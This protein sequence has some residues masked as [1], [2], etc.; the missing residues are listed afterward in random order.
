VDGFCGA[1]SLA[2]T[3][4][5]FL[6]QSTFVAD[7]VN[8][9]ISR[10]MAHQEAQQYAV[11][12]DYSH[13]LIS[14]CQRFLA[15]VLELEPDKFVAGVNTLIAEAPQPE[16]PAEAVMAWFVLK[17][18]VL[19]GAEDHHVWFHQRV[20]K[21]TCAFRSRPPAAPATFA[22]AH[23]AA[24]LGG[25]A[26]DYGRTF[27]AAHRW[28]AAIKAAGLLRA[29]PARTWHV[30]ELGRAVYVSPATLA[31]SFRRIF[32]VTIMQY[33]ARSRLRGVV[34]QVRT[35]A[36]S[37]EGILE[38][39]GYRSRKDAYRWFR[40]LTGLTLSDVR[41]L[42]DAEYASLIQVSLALP[43]ADTLPATRVFCRALGRAVGTEACSG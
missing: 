11:R 1:P 2:A 32:G 40:R 23:V 13:L 29:N 33:Q 15:S 39:C 41:R 37:I 30:T 16:T 35:T 24:S 4:I 12:M 3:R 25:F 7:W 21:I 20:D 19:R 27:N 5:A 8:L 22:P 18:A 36:A 43:T 17:D 10:T 31:R 6:F 14:A 38:G 26:R 34:A 28:P 42:T 9:V